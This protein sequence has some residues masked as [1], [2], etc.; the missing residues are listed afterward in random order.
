MPKR[1]RAKIPVKLFILVPYL[2]LLYM[3]QAMVLPR[4]PVMGVKP[5]ILPLAV[6]GLALF[7]G[8]VT[9]G[10]VG[11]AAGMLCDLSF[12]QPTV[13]FTIILTLTGLSLGVLSDTVLAQGFPSYFLC[14]LG[15]LIVCAACQVVPL[16]LF[17]G[18]S[19][20]PLLAT[21]VRQTLVSLIFTVP[22][23]YVSRYIGRIG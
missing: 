9:G 15:A 12:N 13:Q 6:A 5:L 3:L 10:A 8:H 2:L 20:A 7:G 19:I 1:R 16:V 23:Y 11:L 14:S 4:M 21:A 18:A 17:H 22:L